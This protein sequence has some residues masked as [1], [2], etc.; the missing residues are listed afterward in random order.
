MIEEKSKI[1]PD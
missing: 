1:D